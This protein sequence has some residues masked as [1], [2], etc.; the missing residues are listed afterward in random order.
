MEKPG[1]GT[2]HISGI[3]ISTHVHLFGLSNPMDLFSS[4]TAIV[5]VLTFAG[6]VYSALDSIKSADQDI[7]DYQDELRQLSR[8]FTIIH[9]LFEKA[10]QGSTPAACERSSVQ[11]LEFGLARFCDG[12]TRVDQIITNARQSP[13][14]FCRM[15]RVYKLRSRDNDLAKLKEQISSIRTHIQMILQVNQT[16]LQ[17]T[18]L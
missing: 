4:A 11:A 8:E 5:G 9:Q 7:Q 17:I 14:R 16:N 3:S 1:A 15:V 12:L 6:T 13:G 2:S 10:Y 18:S